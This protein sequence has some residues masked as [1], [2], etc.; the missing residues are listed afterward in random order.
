[1]RDG[2]HG[3]NADAV[4]IL[5]CQGY[6]ALSNSTAAQPVGRSG[7]SGAN[8]IPPAQPPC[9]RGSSAASAGH[10]AQ[11]AGARHRTLT[12]TVRVWLSTIT[13]WMTTSKCR[14]SAPP[15]G[16]SGKESSHEL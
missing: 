14:P 2:T 5:A 13:T 11:H 8:G 12:S 3:R 15:H 10:R 9:R 16:R 4:D 7:P 1:D 6:R